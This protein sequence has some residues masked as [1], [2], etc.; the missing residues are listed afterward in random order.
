MQRAIVVYRPEIYDVLQDIIDR[1][2]AVA[3]DPHSLDE[4]KGFTKADFEDRLEVSD[5]DLMVFVDGSGS[6][7]FISDPDTFWLIFKDQLQL[8]LSE[9]MEEVQS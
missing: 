7:H 2:I 3:V 4:L 5:A 9:T 8:I 6:V 1:F